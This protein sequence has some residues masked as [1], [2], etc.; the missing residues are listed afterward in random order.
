MENKESLAYFA[1]NKAQE[2]KAYNFNK[3][4]KEAFPRVVPNLEDE[5]YYTSLFNTT[6]FLIAREFDF[7]KSLTMWENWCKWRVSY[8]PHETK[9]EEIAN[10]LETCKSFHLGEDKN[11]N[12]VIIL[13]MS[14]NDPNV[15]DE[16]TLRFGCWAVETATAL[17]EQVY[18]GK[19]ITFIVDKRNFSKK[20][21]GKG[22]NKLMK[23][24][25]K[26]L[27]D[28][29]PERLEK[30]YLIG[31]DWY[32]RILFGIVRPFLSEK[33]R[34]KLN[35]IDD[36]SHLFKHISADNLMKEYGGNI[37][38]KYDKYEVFNRLELLK[39]EKAKQANPNTTET[40]PMSM[41]QVT[42][43]EQIIFSEQKTQFSSS[44]TYEN[45]DLELGMVSEE[46]SQ[47]SVSLSSYTSKYKFCKF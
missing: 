23:D 37:D 8:R 18:G 40:K 10:E 36:T 35:L 19:K 26:I 13:L 5:H 21:M 6:R 3:I 28:Y 43:E 31:A 45:D 47:V 11:H 44:N 27:Q 2:E 42:K 12:A 25:A 39:K 29:Y 24:A 38:F 16:E 41:V 32:F 4:T 46:S 7:K 17:S 34:N 14:R 1:L 9:F 20:Q 22:G 33:T 15:S 30:F